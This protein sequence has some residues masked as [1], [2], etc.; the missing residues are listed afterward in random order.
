VPNH[1]KGRGFHIHRIS[2]NRWD[3]V[4]TASGWKISKRQLRALDGNEGAR[5]ILLGT[6][7]D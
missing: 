7:A 3:F 5:E 1:G 4:R 2:A 6:F